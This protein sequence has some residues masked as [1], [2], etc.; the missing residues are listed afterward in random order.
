MSNFTSGL[1]H[2]SQ[3]PIWRSIAPK[4]EVKFDAFIH[5]NCGEEKLIRNIFQFHT[6]TFD[7]ANK[8]IMSCTLIRN[9]APRSLFF[10][11]HFK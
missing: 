11:V 5:F 6:L 4:P 8:K 10:A 7:Q 2:D 3:S 9:V 1:V